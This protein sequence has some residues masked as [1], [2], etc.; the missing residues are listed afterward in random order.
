MSRKCEMFELT[1]TLVLQRFTQTVYLDC[2]SEKVVKRC[3]ILVMCLFLERNVR[4]R[5]K[6]LVFNQDEKSKQLKKIY[7]TCWSAIKRL[8]T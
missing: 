8:N 4:A 6:V 5:L 7:V 3:Y 1:A 2:K